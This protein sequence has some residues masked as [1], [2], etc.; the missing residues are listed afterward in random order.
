MFLPWV[1]PFGIFFLSIQPLPFGGVI[2]RQ[3]IEFHLHLVPSF[4]QLAVIHWFFFLDPRRHLCK[5]EGAAKLVF[6]LVLC[7]SLKPLG[8]ACGFPHLICLVFPALYHCRGPSAL[9]P[10]SLNA[11]HSSSSLYVSWIAC[12][13][14]MLMG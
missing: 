6:R 5:G 7:K 11:I 2:T 13:L 1:L 14:V 4:K 8:L 9:L 12:H 10:V 3:G